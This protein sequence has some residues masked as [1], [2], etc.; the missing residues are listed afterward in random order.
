MPWRTI[1]RYS[2]SAG[3]FGLMAAAVWLLA[4]CLRLRRGPRRQDVPGLPIAFYLAALL[5]II[6]LR[7]GLR[8]ICWLQN[9]PQLRPLEMTLSQWQRGPGAFVYHVCG[10]MLWFVPMGIIVARRRPG[11]RWHHALLAGAALSLTVEALQWLL[12]TGIPD[13]DDVLLNALGAAAGYGL[14]RIP[15]KGA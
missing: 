12:G 13:V 1:T 14:A 4:R 5:Q 7:F 10:N 15:I 6:G 3:G 11:A 8:P 9:P 2:L